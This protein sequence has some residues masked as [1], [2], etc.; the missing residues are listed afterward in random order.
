MDLA[1]PAQFTRRLNLLDRSFHLQLLQC[2][3]F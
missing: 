3:V 1:V 2:R